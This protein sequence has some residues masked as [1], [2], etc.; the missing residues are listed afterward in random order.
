[1]M[2]VWCVAGD[3][4]T[5]SAGIHYCISH[6]GGGG[7]SW[8]PAAVVTIL[9]GTLV[10]GRYYSPRT[11]QLDDGHVGTT[12]CRGPQGAMDGVYFVKVPLA[13]LEKQAL[14]KQ[15]LAAA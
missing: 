6:P 2:V 11:V 8:D 7:G 9:P 5:P 13:L 14:D 15:A 10:V 12:Y 1:M 4:S 3:R